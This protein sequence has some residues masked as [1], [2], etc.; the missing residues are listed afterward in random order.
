[1]T[2]MPRL[3]PILQIQDSSAVKT[4]GFGGA[5]YIGSALNSIR[6]FSEIEVDELVVIDLSDP[7]HRQSIQHMQ[8]LEEFCSEGFMPLSYGGRVSSVEEAVRLARLGFEKVIVGTASF[9]N[10]TLMRSIA[11]QLGGQAVVASIDVRRSSADYA[12]FSHS[13]TRLVPLTLE[14]RL[15]ELAT[16]TVGEILLTSID[17]EGRRV[18]IDLALVQAAVGLTEVP[19]VIAGGTATISDCVSALQAGASAVA[20]GDTAVCLDGPTGTLVHLPPNADQVRSA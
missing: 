4:T 8:F 12:V 5:R 6:M 17:R 3:M 18:G 11:D 10:S 13:G 15:E 20:I 1:M 16:Q 7:N 2:V 9:M 14:Q 19:L